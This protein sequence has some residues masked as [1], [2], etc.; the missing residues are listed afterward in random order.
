VKRE[1]KK[2]KKLKILIDEPLCI[3]GGRAGKLV[4]PHTTTPSIAKACE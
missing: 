2:R 4:D 1:K 3:S